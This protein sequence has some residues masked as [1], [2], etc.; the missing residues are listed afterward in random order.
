MRVIAIDWSGGVDDRSSSEK[1]WLADV[2]DTELVDLYN[3]YTRVE[4][5]ER[6]REA[7]DET[8]GVIVGLD[9]SFSVP[10]RF[11]TDKLGSTTAEELWADLAA[12]KYDWLAADAREYFWGRLKG[13]QA[14]DFVKANAFRITEDRL[15]GMRSRKLRPKSVFQIGGAGAVGTGSIRGMEH[16]ATLM[17]GGFRI[18]PFHNQAEDRPTVVEIYPRFFTQDTTNTSPQGRRAFMDKMFPQVSGFARNLALTS[19]DSFDAAVSALSMAEYSGNLCHLPSIR[20]SR[21]RRE[22][23]IWTPNWDVLLPEWDED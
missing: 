14:N 9:F 21:L 16:L 3:G 13:H 2:R 7:A 23:I 18:W 12:R 8:P 6:I 11:L 4:I 5:I 17:N 19:E 22:G 20:N 1:I 10:E 15:R